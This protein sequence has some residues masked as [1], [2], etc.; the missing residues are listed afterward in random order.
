LNHHIFYNGGNS[1]LPHHGQIK[2]EMALKKAPITLILDRVI[3]AI[4]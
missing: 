1:L 4:K 2:G 3:L